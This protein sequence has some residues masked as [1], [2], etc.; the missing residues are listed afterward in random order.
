MHFCISKWKF[1]Q[2]ASLPWN[3]ATAINGRQPT[4]TKINCKQFMTSWKAEKYSMPEPMS[5]NCKERRL[6]G[7]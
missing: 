1:R 4:N 7:F 5:I 2:T 3:R 6:S